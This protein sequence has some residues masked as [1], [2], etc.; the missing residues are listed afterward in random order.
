MRIPLRLTPTRGRTASASS[1]RCLLP[2]LLQSVSIQPDM[3]LG[4]GPYKEQ[5]DFPYA[6][7][8]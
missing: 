3:I 4:V 2:Y 7:P 8:T 6:N 5:K 1:S